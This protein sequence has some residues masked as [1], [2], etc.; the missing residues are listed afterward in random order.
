MNNR[1]HTVWYDEGRLARK[2]GKDINDCPYKNGSYGYAQWIAGY[3]SEI[4][5]YVD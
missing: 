3:N 1:P 4:I 2:L 5:L